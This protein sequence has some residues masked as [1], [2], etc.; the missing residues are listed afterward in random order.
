MPASEA[1]G[2]GGLV[3]KWLE[4]VIAG[5]PWTM[6]DSSNTNKITTDADDVMTHA[7]QKNQFSRLRLLTG[8][9]G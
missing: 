8:V 6:I 3:K 9:F 2:A 4:L 7:N 1:S 5:I